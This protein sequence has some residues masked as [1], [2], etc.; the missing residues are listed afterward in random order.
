MRL[1]RGAFLAVAGFL[2]VAV[3]VVV[4]VRVSKGRRR[5]NE[6]GTSK[7]NPNGIAPRVKSLAEEIGDALDGEDIAELF[8]SASAYVSSEAAGD[9]STDAKLSLYGCFKQALKGD[10][11]PGR[12]WGMEAGMKWDAWNARRGDTPSEVM[13]RYVELLDGAAPG[14]RHGEAAA[15][16]DCTSKGGGVGI[17][18]GPTVSLMGKMGG[19]GAE[20][21]DET[22]IGQLC[23]RVAEGDTEAVR[24]LLAR[25]PDLAFQADKDGMTPLHWAADRDKLEVLELLLASL[26]AGAE[27]AARLAARDASGDTPLHYAVNSENYK[28]ARLLLA[29]GAEARLANEDGETPLELAKEWDPPLVA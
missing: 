21:V 29:W 4:W 7:G 18:T 11:P 22:P 3:A 9:L 20:D 23:E 5:K 14:W 15:D 28:V 2:T 6:G 27:A 19:P 25:Q 8:E 1:R 12:P 10:C 24:E 13:H 16:G 26:G 17:S